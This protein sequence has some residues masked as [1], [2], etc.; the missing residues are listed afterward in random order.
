MCSLSCP[1][2]RPDRPP[3]SAYKNLRTRSWP[4]YTPLRLFSF[5]NPFGA[6]PTCQG[7]GNTIGL[8]LDLDGAVG[9]EQIGDLVPQGFVHVVAVGALQPLYV[10]RILDKVGLRIEL[11]DLLLQ[12]RQL[13]EFFR[14]D[15]GLAAACDGNCE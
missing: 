10:V 3:P 6:C 12:R 9:R 13:L 2:F 1:A 7:F 8:D 11:R 14:A 5:N 4:Q 15:F